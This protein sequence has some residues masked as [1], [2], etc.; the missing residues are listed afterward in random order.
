MN[1][2]KNTLEEIKKYIGLELS[3]CTDLPELYELD[4][5]KYFN[6][7]LDAP[8]FCS[9]EY[10][11]LLRISGNNKIITKVEPNGNKRLAIFIK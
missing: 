5:N 6:I 10:D 9:Q 8:V 3:H 1:I 2:I 7:V 11:K 4:G